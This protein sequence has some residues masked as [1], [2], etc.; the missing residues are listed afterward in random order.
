MHCVAIFRRRIIQRELDFL[1]PSILKPE[2]E[3]DL[4][5]KL[6]GS[7]RQAIAAEWEI[8]VV[9]SFA[10][11]A[12]VGYEEPIGSV[13]PDLF[14]RHRG[15][16]APVEFVADIVAVSD[17]ETDKRNPSEFFFSEVGRIAYS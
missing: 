9:A 8:V 4:L 11:I 7:N 3:K 5:C 6:N 14:V 10:R 12:T 2:R 1:R 15:E 16:S 17:L 13:R